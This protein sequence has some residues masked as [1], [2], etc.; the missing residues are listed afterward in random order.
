MTTSDIEEGCIVVGGGSINLTVYGKIC[1]ETSYV[2][3][4]DGFSGTLRTGTV[5][6]VHTHCARTYNHMK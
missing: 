4:S 3:L 5:K 6:I 1:C 2:L